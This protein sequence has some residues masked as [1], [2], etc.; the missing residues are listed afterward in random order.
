MQVKKKE[1]SQHLQILPF[2]SLLSSSI[3]KL[4]FLSLSE[5]ASEAD[6]LIPS[7]ISFANLTTWWKFVHLFSTIFLFQKYVLLKG[8]CVIWRGWDRKDYKNVYNLAQL[9]RESK[10]NDLVGDDPIEASS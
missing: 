8:G 4:W 6:F 3:Q 5:S 10:Q 7:F 2:S 1:V 9:A